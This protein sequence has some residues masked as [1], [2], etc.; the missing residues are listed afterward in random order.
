[1]SSHFIFIICV[2]ILPFVSSECFALQCADILRE[3]SILLSDRSADELKQLPFAVALTHASE[4]E[5]SLSGFSYSDNLTPAKFDGLQSSR[6]AGVPWIAYT[7]PVI[8]RL[9]LDRATFGEQPRVAWQRIVSTARFNLGNF[10]ERFLP[11][12]S[13]INSLWHTASVN[14]PAK[15]LDSETVYAFHLKTDETERLS[16]ELGKEVWFEHEFGN[17]NLRELDWVSL[18]FSGFKAR[19]SDGFEITGLSVSRH[20]T[21]QYIG[22]SARA[23]FTSVS[24]QVSASIDLP[25]KLA[26]EFSIPDNVDLSSILRFEMRNLEYKEIGRLLQAYENPKSK[27]FEV[28][29][30][31]K[32]SML[33]PDNQE[34]A[35]RIVNQGVDSMEAHLAPYFSIL[36]VQS[37]D[38]NMIKP[39]LDEKVEL[40]A[41]MQFIAKG[42]LP[43][44][45]EGVFGNLHGIWSHQAQFLA[46][47][48]NLSERDRM[49]FSLF[50]IEIMAPRDD[51]WPLWSVLFDN[52]G[53]SVHSNR[54]WRDRIENA[55]G[56]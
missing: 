8:S 18:D 31:F 25:G 21:L 11:Y 36:P 30:S 56:R 17:A 20:S 5:L 42:R 54:Y 38:G 16:R 48:R 13:N 32:Q 27:V 14:F 45:K 6:A 41:F 26:F 9:V 23:K 51:L 1:M 10:F 50:L 12:F 52:R 29:N 34:Y 39:A 15:S 24:R 37:H 2:L 3:R 44:E 22:F 7:G 33:S 47:M 4:G 53:M 40:S 46:G 49:I 19:S 35:V 55:D 43:Y 28:L